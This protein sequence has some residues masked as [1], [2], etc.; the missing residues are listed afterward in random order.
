[1]PSDFLRNRLLL[2]F[3][4]R[5][6]NQVGERFVTFRIRWDRLL[7]RWFPHPHAK[8]NAQHGPSAL[9][10]E[11]D[12]K[13]K[14]HA[15][16]GLFNVFHNKSDDFLDAVAEGHIQIVGPPV[17]GTWT[18]YHDFD[19]SARLQIAADVL[20]TSMGYR[21]RLGDLSGG[22]LQLRDFYRGCVHVHLPNLFLIGFT[23]PIIGNIPSISEVQ[24]R[25]A[26]GVLSG[27]TDCPRTWRSDRR[28]PGSCCAPNTPPSTPTRSTPWSSSRTAMTWQETW[29]SCRPG[30]RSGH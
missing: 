18:E 2:S 23:R 27:S 28:P 1:M 15:K 26:A 5:L 24:A 10:R 29:A 6:R 21:S 20:V 22:V 3:D 17:D 4:K 25:F 30:P 9:R 12:L 7:A 14:A 8:A 13:L 19:R 16:G 11:W